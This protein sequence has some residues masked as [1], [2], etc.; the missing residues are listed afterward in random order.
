MHDAPDR[1]GR[2]QLWRA[3]AALGVTLLAIAALVD[4]ARP[5]AHA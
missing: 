2:A 3:I 4:I 1:T 5:D